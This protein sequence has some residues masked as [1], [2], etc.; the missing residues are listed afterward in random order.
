MQ[1]KTWHGERLLQTYFKALYGVDFTKHRRPDWLV[2]SDGRRLEFDGYSPELRI[3]IE[4][5][6]ATHYEYC[7]KFHSSPADLVRQKSNDTR[8]RYLCKKNGVFL[9]IISRLYTQYPPYKLPLLVKRVY[10]RNSVA[11]PRAYHGIMVK[12][13]GTVWQTRRVGFH[14]KLI[15]VD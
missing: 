7:P 4:H 5:N 10:D 12:H 8:K 14:N 2:T 15:K 11:L 9:V 3:A 13:D 6:G 1:N